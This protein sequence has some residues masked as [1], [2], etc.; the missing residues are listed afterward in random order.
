MRKATDNNGESNGFLHRED[1]EPGFEINK[2]KKKG[3]QVCEFAIMKTC[4]LQNI[5]AQQSVAA[6]ATNATDLIV[7]TGLPKPAN[8]SLSGAERM[9][10]ALNFFV[11]QWKIMIS[12][13]G[14]H[15][16][17]NASLVHFSL[18]CSSFSFTLQSV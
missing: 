14:N 6:A 3:Q 7:L 4:E 15:I 5:T 9:H 10:R 17:Y 1:R 13:N 11:T 12:N 8:T 18:L 2:E 16:N